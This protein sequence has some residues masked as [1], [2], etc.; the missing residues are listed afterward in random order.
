MSDKFD[1]RL[2]ATNYHLDR[3]HPPTSLSHTN[4]SLSVAHSPR[5]ALDQ[6][7]TRPVTPPRHEA[8]VPRM[9]TTPPL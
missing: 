1:I 4:S 3:F 6:P 2:A 5:L 7:E 8:A 9:V